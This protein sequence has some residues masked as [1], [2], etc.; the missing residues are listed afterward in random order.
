MLPGTHNS[1]CFYGSEEALAR[2]DIVS[3]FLLTQ[4]EDVYE[5]LV[6]GVRYL[7]I[8]VG[9]YRDKGAGKLIN[10]IDISAVL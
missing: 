5:Q 4:D 7:D 8:R 2:G 6:W 10:N 3:R 9:Y 1:G